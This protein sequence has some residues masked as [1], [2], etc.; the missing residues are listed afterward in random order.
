MSEDTSTN[1]AAPVPGVEKPRRQPGAAL[2]VSPL[3][4]GAAGAPGEH[5]LPEEAIDGY[6]DV[7]AAYEGTGGNGEGQ[8]PVP[9]PV[10]DDADDADALERADAGQASTDRAKPGPH[11]TARE[12]ASTPASGT[13]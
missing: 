4:D 5:L 11:E 8:K 13:K 12:T 2:S 10:A 7:A 1:P 9:D 6:P 3:P